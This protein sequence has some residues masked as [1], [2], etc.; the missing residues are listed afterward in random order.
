[1][2]LPNIMMRKTLN[3]VC[4]LFDYVN[5]LRNPSIPEELSMCAASYLKCTRR[6]ST[7]FEKT[8]PFA[9]SP[10]GSSDLALRREHKGTT[11]ST[12]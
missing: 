9:L 2:L 12:N 3:I 7:H 6:L 10:P 8:R 5:Y 1:M 11:Q 4:V